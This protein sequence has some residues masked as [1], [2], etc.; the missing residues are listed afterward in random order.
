M[1][2]EGTRKE[3]PKINIRFFFNHCNDLNEVRHFYSEVIGLQEKA[4]NIEWGYL[5]YQS[6]GFEMMFFKDE[7]KVSHFEEW[8]DQPGWEGGTLKVTS[9][10]IEIPEEMFNEVFRRLK[11]SGVKMFKEVPEWRTDNYWG[12]S[13]MDPV[14]N[15]LEVYTVPKKAPESKTWKQ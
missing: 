12:L 2:Q 7:K 8:T 11:D 5:C 6:D 14:G 1:G 13:V 9:W 3:K 4:F 15:T 10:A